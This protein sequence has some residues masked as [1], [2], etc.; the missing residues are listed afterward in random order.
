MLRKDKVRG[1]GEGIVNALTVCV[2]L[3][4]VGSRLLPAC[5]LS[6][7]STEIP[8]CGLILGKSSLQGYL[9]CKKTHPP[10]TLP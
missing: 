7:V 8:G 10:R 3:L 9:T 2:F 4:G 5:V 1:G 6:R